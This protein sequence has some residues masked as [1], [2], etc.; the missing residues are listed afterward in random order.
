MDFSVSYIGDIVWNMHTHIDI[1]TVI[2]HALHE[3]PSLLISESL[4]TD[5]LV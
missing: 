1:I 5:Y 4:H 2:K 3:R